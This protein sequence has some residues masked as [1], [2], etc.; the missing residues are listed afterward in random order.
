MSFAETV[1][2]IPIWD[3]EEQSE[4]TLKLIDDVEGGEKIRGDFHL[5]LVDNASPSQRTQE[6]L[7]KVES[8]RSSRITVLRNDKNEGYGKAANRGIF[9]GLGMGA[10]FGI[11]L[12]NDI[13]IRDPDFM[14]NAFVQHLRANPKQLMGSRYIDFNGDAIYD[15]KHVTP[16]LE[17]WCFAFHR[18]FVE[19]VGLFDGEIFNW[20]EDAELCIRAVKN[21]YPIVQSP[22]FEWD[23]IKPQIRGPLVHASGKT[24]FAKLDY[25]AIAAESRRYVT[26]KHF[27]GQ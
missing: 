15:G 24:S 17:G 2:S 9:F 3:S 11:V 10:Q 8:S 12:N 5:V 23:G 6:A 26:K 1:I 18:L 22:A 16:Y 13:E 19:N 7:R 27:S 25:K 14:E 21:G 20:H 4:W